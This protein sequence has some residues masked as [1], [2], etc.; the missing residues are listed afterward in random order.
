MRGSE[1]SGSYSFTI[2]KV[3]GEWTTKSAHK[4]RVEGTLEGNRLTFGTSPQVTELTVSGDHMSGATT[5][6]ES[7]RLKIDLTKAK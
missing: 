7:H 2:A 4:A 5:T 3:A 1:V 6:P